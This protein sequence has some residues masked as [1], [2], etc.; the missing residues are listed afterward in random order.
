MNIPLSIEG[1][2]SNIERPHIVVISGP[3]GAGKGTLVDRVMNTLSDEEPERKLSCSWTTRPRRPDEPLDAYTFVDRETFMKRAVEGGFLEW[4]EFGGNCYGTP[5]LEDGQKTLLE[6]EVNGALQVRETAQK[7]GALSTCQFIYIIPPN[8]MELAVQLLARGDRMTRT[9]KVE[10]FATF[11]NEE[12]AKARS[13]GA[14]VVVN[15]KIETAA[16][17]VLSAI[18]G[19]FYCPHS[20]D[21][22][23]DRYHKFGPKILDILQELYLNDA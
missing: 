6:I 20:L 14:H 3:S 19:E 7:L 17:N 11:I 18:S 12:L 5:A 16:A 4:A 1:R 9:E 13:L 22:L 15:D 21:M 23:L 2:A 8:P 10:R